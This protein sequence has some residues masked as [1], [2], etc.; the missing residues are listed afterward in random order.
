MND[1]RA[2]EK[3]SIERVKAAVAEVGKAL[4]HVWETQGTA[5]AN[6][7]LLAMLVAQKEFLEARQEM[8]LLV[9]ELRRS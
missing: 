8:D 9:E 2:A 1:P 3:A 5:E 7:A 6:N 4:N